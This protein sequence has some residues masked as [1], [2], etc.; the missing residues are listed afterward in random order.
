MKGITDE[1]EGTKDRDVGSPCV[2][3]N[4]GGVTGEKDELLLVGEVGGG[5]VNCSALNTQLVQPIKEDGRIDCVKGCTRLRR[6]L[7]TLTRAVSVL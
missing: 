7:V 5:P 2:T 6:S 3:G 4:S 1:K